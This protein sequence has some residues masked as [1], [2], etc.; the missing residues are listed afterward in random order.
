MSLIRVFNGKGFEE[1]CELLEENDVDGFVEELV[2]GIAYRISESKAA[3]T[4]SLVALEALA[5]NLGPN[6]SIS[7]RLEEYY[8]SIGASASAGLLHRLHAFSGGSQTKLPEMCVTVGSEANQNLMR[9]GPSRYIKQLLAVLLGLLP[10]GA[11]VFLVRT[12]LQVL[13]AL[14]IRTKWNLGRR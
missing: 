1:L 2:F 8:G 5:Q 7:I 13:Q 12:W 6:P 9:K 3:S 10:R 14:K 4:V 11:R